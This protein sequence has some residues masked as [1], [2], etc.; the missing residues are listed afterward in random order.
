MSY[1][2]T[3]FHINNIRM[4]AFH[5][6][7]FNKMLLAVIKMFYYLYLNKYLYFLICFCCLIIHV[8]FALICAACLFIHIHIF[9]WSLLQYVFIKT[10]FIYQNKNSK[11]ALT[12]MWR[13][14]CMDEI[15]YFNINW[16]IL[17]WAQNF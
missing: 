11:F 8:F 1:L 4:I 3:W 9:I 6:V 2:L 12:H 13:H 16:T 7:G 14:A 17:N 10:H 15:V 5:L